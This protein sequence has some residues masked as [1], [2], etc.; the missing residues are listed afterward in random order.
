MTDGKHLLPQPGD[1]QIFVSLSVW[2]GFS[3]YFFFIFWV[4]SRLSSSWWAQTITDTL[5]TWS[6]TASWPSFISSGRS[7]PKRTSLSWWVNRRICQIAIRPSANRATFGGY[8]I[9]LFFF[10]LSVSRCCRAD[11]WSIRCVSA[12][13]RSTSCWPTRRRWWL[14]SSWSIRPRISSC[15]TAAFPIWTCTT[16]STWRPTATSKSLSLCTTSSS[17]CWPKPTEPSSNRPTN[18][19]PAAAAAAATTTPNRCFT[20]D[21]DSYFFI[22]H[23]ILSSSSTCT[24]T[25]GS[26]IK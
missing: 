22:S 5:P 19:R 9:Y 23:L 4:P 16:I 14:A 26:R 7:N 24:F 3:V 21:R 15:R 25:I 10:F 13:P 8:F 17:S 20:K 18:N 12:T 11:I 6:P 2:L 1:L